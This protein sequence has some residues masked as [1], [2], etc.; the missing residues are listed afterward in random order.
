MNRWILPTLVLAFL[1][2]ACAAQVAIEPSASPTAS[3]SES[4]SASEPLPT[5]EP[6]DKETDEPVTGDVPAA[7]IEAMK[8][9]AAARA[10]VD[11]EDVAVV[12]AEAV[13]WND[14]SL[15]CPEPGMGYTQ[16]LVPGYHVILEADSVEYDYRAADNG[17]FKLCENP[18]DPGTDGGIVDY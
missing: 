9:D 4:A 12:N 7:M 5:V 15:G 16:A 17:A 14:G 3:P 18:G 11:S 6:A 1:I 2:S 10:G 8:T 13:T